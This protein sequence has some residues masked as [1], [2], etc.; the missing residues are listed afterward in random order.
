MLESMPSHTP[1][2][3]SASVDLQPGDAVGRY[4][5]LERMSGAI[6]TR[7]LAYDPQL[8]RKVVLE[9]SSLDVE[10]TTRAR[11]RQLARLHHPNLVRVHDVGLYRQRLFVAREYAPGRPL[12]R[13]LEESPPPRERLERLLE[14]GRAL[15]AMHELG[16]VHGAIEPGQVIIGRRAKLLPLFFRADELL[17]RAYR[18]PELEA[19]N[20]PDIASDQFAFCVLVYLALFETLPFPEGESVELGPSFPAPAPRAIVSALAR[21]LHVRPGLRFPTMSALLAKLGDRKR[22]LAG[23]LQ[24][25]LS[26]ASLILLASWSASK[27]DPDECPGDG[28]RSVWDDARKLEIRRAFEGTRRT[29][30]L[31]SF[32]AVEQ[33]LGRYT[34]AW[35][36]E[37]SS[38]CREGTST[39][40]ASEMGREASQ[41]YCLE[42]RKE[43][44]RG[45]VRALEQADP[46]LVDNVHA[47]LASLPPPTSCIATQSDPS[48]EQFPDIAAAEAAIARSVA[49][50]HGGLQDRSTEAARLALARAER[51][52][53]PRTLARASTA[54]GLALHLQHS[55]D[56]RSELERAFSLCLSSADPDSAVI[57]ARALAIEAARAGSRTE[58]ERWMDHA[59]AAGSRASQAGMEHFDPESARGHIAIALGDYPEALEHFSRSLQHTEERYGE[60]AVLTAINRINVAQS[61]LDMGRATRARDETLRA[62]EALERELGDGH[63]T[64]ARANLALATAEFRL[65]NSTATREHAERAVAIFERAGVPSDH[66]WVGDAHLVLGL[67]HATE[68]DF[69]RALDE[70]LEALR[71]FSFPSV[72]SQAKL[73]LVEANLTADYLNLGDPYGAEPHARRAVELAEAVHGSEHP[74]TAV[75]LGNLGELLLDTSQYERARLVLERANDILVRRL[76]SDHPQRAFLLEGLARVHIVNGQLPLALQH[77]EQ[78]FELRER[79]KGSPVA[80][81]Q[82]RLLIADA[83]DRVAAPDRAAR[84]RSIALASLADQGEAGRDAI[85]QIER[86]VSRLDDD[87]ASTTD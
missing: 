82:T 77:L 37:W 46:E 25:G 47:V 31:R 69:S 79:S 49:L 16:L 63:P 24:W 50:R 9:F 52:G 38:S 80:L 48:P 5:T 67:A 30:A 27:T 43:T 15:A 12:A 57:V 68:R 72:P 45:F 19:G 21:G 64:T 17:P 22:S 85:A 11:L 84:E 87:V 14:V 81:A 70:H 74:E 13:W 71:I 6:I 78:A 7:Y 35:Q 4:L 62:I 58:A 10:E 18:A 40:D 66:A 32:A 36:R 33:A 23:P 44:L 73:A 20:A 83:A 61:A 55:P 39:D 65:G 29:H 28:I 42:R 26:A 86:I 41:L 54:Y 76:G 75:A 34:R 8:D 53:E 51:A 3:S 59:E 1:P 56:A 2:V 60:D